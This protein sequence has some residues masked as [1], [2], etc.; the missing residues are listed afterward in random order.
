MSM[1][2]TWLGL[3]I[4]MA[5]QQVW[6][7]LVAGLRLGG[8]RTA[9]ERLC[10]HPLHQRLDVLAADLAPLGASRPRNIR[11]PAKGYSR[12]SRSRRR[13]IARS[14]SSRRTAPRP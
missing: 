6:I 3:V 9:I 5:T 7:D 13:M 14:A 8:A 2:Q 10:P 1:A 12:C 11:E 4:S